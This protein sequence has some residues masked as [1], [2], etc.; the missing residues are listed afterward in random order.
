MLILR[1]NPEAQI[2]GF[3]S[4]SQKRG[5]IFKG[6]STI[7]TSRNHHPIESV[8]TLIQ[9]KTTDYLIGD[10]YLEET[11]AQQLYQ[12]IQTEISYYI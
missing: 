9:A 10:P 1:F 11:M 4:G 8:T 6:L 5:P 12:A 7:E 3:I 2:F